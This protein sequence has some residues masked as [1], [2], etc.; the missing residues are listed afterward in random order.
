MPINVVINI[1]TISILNE[2]TQKTYDVSIGDVIVFTD[3][4]DPTK[5]VES[6]VKEI[7]SSS[8]EI[9]LLVEGDWDYVSA[10]EIIRVK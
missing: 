8:H 3:Q 9:C 2:E 6:K 4:D 1:K 10:E 7:Y 5:E